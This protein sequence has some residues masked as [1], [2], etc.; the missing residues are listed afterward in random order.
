MVGFEK[1]FY[2]FSEDAAETN[3]CIEVFGSDCPINFPFTVS[4]ATSDGTAGKFA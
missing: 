3:V 2:A 1:T 4:L